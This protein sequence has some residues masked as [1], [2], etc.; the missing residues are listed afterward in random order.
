MGKSNEGDRCGS[1]LLKGILIGAFGLTVMAMASQANATY[2]R[3][4]ASVSST[5]TPWIPQ[6][7][8]EQINNQSGLSS[9]YVNGVTD[10]DSYVS[11]VTHSYRPQYEWWAEAGTGA[12]S[13]YFDLGDVFTVDK[14]AFWNED[15]T[16]ISFFSAMFSVDNTTWG[17]QNSFS[18]SDTPYMVDYNADN[19]SLSS[20]VR[21]RYIKFDLIAGNP[22]PGDNL[23]QPT[24]SIGEVAFSVAETVP[25]PTTMLLFGAGLAG[26]L[27]FRRKR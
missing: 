17:N 12:G 21:A 26:L 24:V 15:V 8:V 16:G 14:I 18:P 22:E 20:A 6:T 27:G 1:V 10:Y 5:L 4:A 19:F 3:G 25:E 13:V 11:T 7:D 9:S 2:I 23:N